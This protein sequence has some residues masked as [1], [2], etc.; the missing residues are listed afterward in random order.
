VGKSGRAFVE[1][2]QINQHGGGNPLRRGCLIVKLLMQALLNQSKPAGI[3]GGGGAL[4]LGL[5]Q[6]DLSEFGCYYYRKELSV[7]HT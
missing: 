1:V 4:L 5:G 2:F 6:A 3:D 7:R